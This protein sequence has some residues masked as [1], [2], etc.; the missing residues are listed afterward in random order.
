MRLLIATTVVCCTSLALAEE[1][2]APRGYF[3]L[4][5]GE[6]AVLQPGNKRV[7]A[8]ELLALPR[9]AGLTIRARWSWI[10]PSE[11]RFDFS[12][13]DAQVAR[14]HNAGKRY[15]LL[16]MTGR[17]CS[18][19][20][21]GGAWHRG[22]PVP[23]SDELKQHYGALVAELGKKYAADPLLCGVHITGPTFPS[24]EMHPAPGIESVAGYSDQAM[25]DAWGASIDA[26]AAAFPRTACLL[27]IS[28]QPPAR[29]YLGAVVD[30]GRE[31]LG[32]RF[33]LQHNALKASTH[34]LAPH[35]LFIS[36]EAKKG[37]RVGFE[38]VCPATNA[39]R[40]G[41][42]DV[43]DGIELGK[44]AGGVFFDVYPPDL[45]ALR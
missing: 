4:Q 11:G 10:H 42:R 14:C 3:A 19:E 21:I 34:P 33:T 32:E 6:P 18:P 38:M 5:P 44:A 29:R 37:V 41:S 45:K 17:D 28:V 2:R 36:A 43:M 20:W 22:A 35:H 31:K 13:L 39:A 24:T 9:V 26:Y 27:S 8:D 40:F 30:Y 25:I 15:K 16:V 7:V 12:F 23:W 1:V